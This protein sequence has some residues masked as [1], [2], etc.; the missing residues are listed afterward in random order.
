VGAD[1][2][3]RNMAWLSSGQHGKD[4]RVIFKVT[5]NRVYRLAY[6]YISWAKAPNYV[7][8]MTSVDDNAFYEQKPF[9]PP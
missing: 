2:V 4:D 7:S 8:I 5:L 1:N 3:R 9:G 6:I